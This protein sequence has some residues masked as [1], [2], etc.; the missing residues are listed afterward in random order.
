MFSTRMAGEHSSLEVGRLQKKL[1]DREMEFNDRRELLEQDLNKERELVLAED[2]RASLLREVEELKTLAKQATNEAVRQSE[3]ILGRLT[4]VQRV[5]EEE[6]R[7]S[8]EM[9]ECLQAVQ[10]AK[11]RLEN[12]VLN[13]ATPRKRR[14]TGGEQFAMTDGGES[15]SLMMLNDDA[16]P[17]SLTDMYTRLAE[18]EDELAHPSCL[19]RSSRS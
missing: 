3:D 1:Y 11:L 10:E 18:T 4:A 17:L 15:N 12:D 6:E 19:T 13:T 5:R 8:A 7:K 9:E 16:G 2:Q 14:I